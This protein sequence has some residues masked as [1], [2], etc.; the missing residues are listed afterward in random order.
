[1]RYD[2][3]QVTHPF[4]AQILHLYNGIMQEPAQRTWRKIN[5]KINRS[6]IFAT[7]SGTE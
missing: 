4:F 6:K 2:C 1:M 3:R 5:V 7:V